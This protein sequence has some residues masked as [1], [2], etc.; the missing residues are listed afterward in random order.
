MNPTVKTK[1]LKALRSGK[2][3]QGKGALR[4]IKDGET[5][6]CCLGV[7]CDLYAK[8]KKIKGWN[9]NNTFSNTEETAVLPEI[10]VKWAG[11]K[12]VGANPSTKST[13]RGLASLND[14][15]VEVNNSFK[16]IANIIEKEL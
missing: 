1:W 5:Q 13:R 10:V 2:Y 11:L 14:S 4:I 16:Q 9:K 3:K 12:K 8:E 15:S 7:L 6:Y